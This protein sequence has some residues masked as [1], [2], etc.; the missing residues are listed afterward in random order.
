MS[1]QLHATIQKLS[2]DLAANILRAIRSMSV[3][4][5]ARLGGSSGGAARRG[6]G[7][8]PKAAAHHAAPRAAR[9]SRRLARRSTQDLEKMA[10]RI[11]SLVKSSKKGI[12]AEAIRSSLKVPRK[13]LPRPLKMALDSKKI[14][15]KGH[16][17]ATMYF[18]A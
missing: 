17:R 4:D 1:T 7:R 5:L 9:G 8:P 16:K 11:I 15:K 3:D 14:R 13:V 6:P 10:E 12:N 2:E 18:G